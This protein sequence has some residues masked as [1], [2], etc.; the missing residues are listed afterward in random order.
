MKLGDKVGSE[1]SSP[2]QGC[3]FVVATP[4][5]NL[6]DITLRAIRIL[7][8]ADLIAAED[9]RHTRRLLAAHN[10]RNQLLSFHEHN[11]ARRTPELL[12]RIR[13]GQQV[14][15]VSDAGTPMVSDPG[16]RLVRAAVDSHIQ[17]VPVPGVSAVMTA[18]CASGLATDQF[19]FIGFPA[20]KKS[21]R[22]E[23]LTRAA[24]FAGT[25]V[26]Y[27]SPRRLMDFLDE[28][29]AVLGDRQAVLA[30]ELTKI[31][32]EF[33]RGPI[34]AIK[35]ELARR[36]AVKGE[37]TL[38]VEGTDREDSPIAAADWERILQGALERNDRAVGEI[39]KE[40][41]G[42]FG[43]KKRE[44]YNKALALKKKNA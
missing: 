24:G 7:G 32:E 21:R 35:R 16:Y 17:V 13:Q 19:A 38:L 5:G 23:Q 1:S 12:Q 6:E 44:V 31:H 26:F 14:A 28:L 2:R 22:L 41:A 30:R 10:I 33:I 37:C 11:E 40:I 27:Q 29:Q 8:D 9:T 20:R 4:I 15:L 39:A 25:L 42:R 43:L 18:L 36:E 3:L 34:S